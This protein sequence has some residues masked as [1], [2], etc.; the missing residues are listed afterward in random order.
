MSFSGMIKEELAEHY[1]NA[2]HC[3]LAELSAIIRMSGVFAQDKKGIC[4]VHVHTE[5][6]TVARKCF[7]Y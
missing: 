5:N 4:Y 6:F 2:R 1:A 7:T 3:K